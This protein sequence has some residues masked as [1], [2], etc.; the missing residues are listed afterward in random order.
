MRRKGGKK[1]FGFT[2]GVGHPSVF[3]HRERGMMTL[4]HGDD[5]VSSGISTDLTWLEEELKKAYEI[6]TRRL[7]LGDKLMKEGKGFESPD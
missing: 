1:P 7:G 3:H 2:R 4:V 6:K 5:Y